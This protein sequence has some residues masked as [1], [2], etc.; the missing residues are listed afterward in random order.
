MVNISFVH[1]LFKHDWEILQRVIT[2]STLSI[3][4]KVDMA[5]E[6]TFR[7]KVII[8]ETCITSPMSFSP[9]FVLVLAMTSIS[10]SMTSSSAH[11]VTY[12]TNVIMYL[13]HV[14]YPGLGKGPTKSIA[15]IS[16]VRLVFMDIRGISFCFR[17]IHIL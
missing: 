11:L 4:F 1:Y 14:L 6:R 5:L 3:E 2:N 15:N 8:F 12:S 17:G 9:T 7:T 13:A 16:N 10:S